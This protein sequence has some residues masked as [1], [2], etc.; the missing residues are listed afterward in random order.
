MVHYMKSFPEYFE[1]TKSGKK[2][3]ELRLND[4][5]VNDAMAFSVGDTIILKEFDPKTSKYTNRC[6]EVEI[7][8]ISPV[9]RP[10]IVPNYVLMSIKLKK[11]KWLGIF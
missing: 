7:T 9:P 4:F 3:H 5:G 10:W 2:S 8:Y 11:K 6:I 1:A